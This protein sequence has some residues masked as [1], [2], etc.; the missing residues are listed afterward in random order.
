MKYLIRDTLRWALR[1]V[2]EPHI[3]RKVLEMLSDDPPRTASAAQFY[4]EWD[5]GQL[6]KAYAAVEKWREEA[7]L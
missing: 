7:G 2:E 6:D 1:K 4:W 5:G 3:K